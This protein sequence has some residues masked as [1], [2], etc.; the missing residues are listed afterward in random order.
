MKQ[1]SFGSMSWTVFFVAIATILL[2]PA[3]QALACNAPIY[4]TDDLTSNVSNSLAADTLQVVLFYDGASP[5]NVEL[6]VQYLD[7][8]NTTC[9]FTIQNLDA[10]TTEIN[11]REYDLNGAQLTGNFEVFGAV[12]NGVI[13]GLAFGLFWKD[14]GLQYHIL[15]SNQVGGTTQSDLV[16]MWPLTMSDATFAARTPQITDANARWQARMAI[17]G[18]TLVGNGYYNFAIH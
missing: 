5:G 4:L 17:D 1:K 13:D 8:T 15:K 16:G 10:F 11:T 12:N 6:R 2:L 14:P 18:A 9:W 7:N 3:T